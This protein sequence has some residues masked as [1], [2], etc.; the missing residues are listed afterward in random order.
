MPTT[1]NWPLLELLCD[2]HFHSGE[3]LGTLL[4]IS[5]AGIWKQ[6]QSLKQHY[7]VDI[8]STPNKGYRLQ[9]PVELFCKQKIFQAID[10]PDH[11]EDI[12][13]F[14]QIGSTNQ[15][16]MD[17]AQ[18]G[19]QKNT[20]CFAEQQTHGKGRQGKT[21]ISPFGHNIYLSLLWNFH[22]DPSELT[23]LSL[24]M[25]VA[26]LQALEIYAGNQNI[27]IKWPND[28]YWQ[29]KKLGGI[30]IEML[31]SPHS[32]C[33]AVIGIG[34]NIQMP[35]KYDKEI[36]QPWT[37]LTHIL[38]RPI[39]RNRLAGLLLNQIIQAILKFTH[40]G[41]TPFLD[42][43]RRH[44]VLYHQAIT[45]QQSNQKIY[46]TA[47]GI[48]DKGELILSNEQNQTRILNSGEVTHIRTE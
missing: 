44:D 33:K 29:G 17:L 4:N 34:L 21:W 37:A 40:A 38:Q 35:Q 42:Y 30:L 12:F 31:S 36:Q 6:I 18:Q 45:F 16:L 1:N 3:K 32:H 22:S 14:P 25:S 15:Y 24:A 39:E 28:I 20:A 9:Q 48:T 8:E 11:I 27:G 2:G 47:Q 10:H 5:R 46:G 26:L 23:G 19:Y 13:L 7:G 41:L 43:W